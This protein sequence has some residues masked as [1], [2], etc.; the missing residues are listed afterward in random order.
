MK[1]KTNIETNV[2]I[3]LDKIEKDLE[4][5]VIEC[6][7]A[8][9]QLANSIANIENT[10]QLLHSQNKETLDRIEKQLEFLTEKKCN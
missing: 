2:L 4:G 5:H 8:K 7:K 10:Q 3:R 6:T 1:Q 9:L